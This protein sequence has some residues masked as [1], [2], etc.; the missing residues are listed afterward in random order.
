MCQIPINL[1]RAATVVEG[2]KGSELFF[3]SGPRQ[4]SPR[5][6]TPQKIVLPPFPRS[7][8]NKGLASGIEGHR[9]ERPQGISLPTGD[10]GRHRR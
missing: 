9:H 6:P 3:R 1:I 4:L 5:Q 2:Q 8:R 10:D 7:V